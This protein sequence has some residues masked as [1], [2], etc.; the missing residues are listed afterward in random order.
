MSTI[1]SNLK[2]PNRSSDI[3]S[4]ERPSSHGGR[5]AAIG[6]PRSTRRA[7]RHQWKKRAMPSFCSS[8]RCQWTAIAQPIMRFENSSNSIF[9]TFETFVTVVTFVAFVSVVVAPTESGGQRPVWRT[10][11]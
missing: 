6:V 8:P 4:N 7:R 9:V 5:V 2:S 10:G 3:V 1:R 11:M